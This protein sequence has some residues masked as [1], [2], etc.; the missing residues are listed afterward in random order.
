MNENEP[1]NLIESHHSSPKRKNNVD[2]RYKVDSQA[3]NIKFGKFFNGA[4]YLGQFFERSFLDLANS[5]LEISDLEPF[6]VANPIF[7]LTALVLI[8]MTNPTVIAHL[9]MKK[10]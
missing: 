7:M 1:A 5:F 6:Y 4:S 3:P 10:L 2:V 9:Q 8:L